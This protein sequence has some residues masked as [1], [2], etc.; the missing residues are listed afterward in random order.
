MKVVWY[1]R[2]LVQPLLAHHTSAKRPEDDLPQTPLN[3]TGFGN[4]AFAGTIGYAEV[5][6]WE[7]CSNLSWLVSSGN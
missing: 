7:S 2:A 1:T 4:V 5:T 3:V 6:L